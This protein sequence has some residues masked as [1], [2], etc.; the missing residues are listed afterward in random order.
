MCAKTILS[1]ADVKRSTVHAILVKTHKK[2]VQ[3]VVDFVKVRYNICGSYENFFK[4]N[5]LRFS[6]TLSQKFY[7]K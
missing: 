2:I 1:G 3:E 5:L 7:A 6:S 4:V